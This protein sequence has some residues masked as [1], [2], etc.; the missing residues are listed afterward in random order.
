M[1]EGVGALVRE[2]ADG[3]GEFVG[4]HLRLARLEFAAD[5][6]SV[7]KRARVLALFVALMLVGYTL[8][9]LGIA[10]CVGGVNEGVTRLGKTLVVFGLVHLATGAAGVFAWTRAR[11]IHAMEV[12]VDELNRSLTTLR[13]LEKVNVR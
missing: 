3:L 12:T 11:G 5:L 8:A 9:M 1:M 2:T 6:Q 4:Q 10:A 13:D 7:A